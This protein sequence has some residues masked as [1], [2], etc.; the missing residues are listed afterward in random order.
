MSVNANT[1]M[2]FGKYKGTPLGK[3]DK[4][5]V[6][7]FLEQD[8][9]KEKLDLY[10]FFTNGDETSDIAKP[11]IDIREDELH[12]LNSVPH[13]FSLW[14]IGQFKAER[15]AHPELYLLL[16]RTAINGWCARDRRTADELIAKQ[17][18]PPPPKPPRP[19][20]IDLLHAELG[21]DVPF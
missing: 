1:P 18:P 15:D 10:N 8:W 5:Y 16:L 20:S 2:P 9:A 4:K 7:W 14:W 13:A 6:A 19:S 12:L 3:V 17:P 11:K 21:E